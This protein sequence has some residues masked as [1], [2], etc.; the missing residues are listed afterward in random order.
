[1][2]FLKR[3][4]AFIIIIISLP[5]VAT[6]GVGLTSIPLLFLAMLLW[7]GGFERIVNKINELESK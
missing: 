7:V 2:L 4:L 3:V 1:M 6:L 5:F